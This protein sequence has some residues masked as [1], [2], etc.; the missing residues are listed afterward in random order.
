MNLLQIIILNSIVQ[1]TVNDSEMDS[2]FKGL[3]LPQ[4]STADR[5]ALDAPLTQMEI[6]TAIM[7]WP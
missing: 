3:N 2:F 7:K 5:E 6:K 1:T 4:F